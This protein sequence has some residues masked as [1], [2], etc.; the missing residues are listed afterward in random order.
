MLTESLNR[1]KAAIVRAK[2]E[3]A[4]QL[5]RRRIG[6]RRW[7]AT[8]PSLVA[9]HTVNLY[10][11]ITKDLLNCAHKAYAVTHVPQYYRFLDVSATT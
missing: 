1:K 8:E 9:C 5:P 3:A 10:Y 6:T 7:A 4:S 11:M 2:E